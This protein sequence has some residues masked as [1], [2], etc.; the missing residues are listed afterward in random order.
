MAFENRPVDGLAEESIYAGYPSPVSD[1]AWNALIE[2][3]A[4]ITPFDRFKF[5]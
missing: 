2:G 3:W 4:L 1:A 5:I